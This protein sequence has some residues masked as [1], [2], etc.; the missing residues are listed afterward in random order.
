MSG[1]LQ[2]DCHG[3]A[4]QKWEIVLEDGTAFVK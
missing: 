4:N 3:L 2:W 1:A